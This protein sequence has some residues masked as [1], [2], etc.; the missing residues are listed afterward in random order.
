VT[1]ARA[2]LVWRAVFAAVGW[3]GLALQFWLLA[4]PAHPVGQLGVWTLNYFSYFTILTNLLV[5]LVLTL[6]VVAPS[7]RA[8]RWALNPSVRARATL[9]L[10]IVGLG[11]HLLLSAGS[12]LQGLG[13]V[14]NFIVHYIMP[15]AALADW[16]LFTPRGG[17]RWSDPFGWLKYPLVYFVWTALHGYASGWWPYWFLNLP[18]LGLARSALVVAALLILLMA[19]GFAF[20]AID[21]S[22]ARRDRTPAPA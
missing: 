16:L 4:W 11:Y 14:G 17:L 13:A 10:T 21:R 15:V 3:T 20:V 19:V 7:S 9:Y 6:P 12:N 1:R 2:A 22:L 8:G 18:Q 5:A